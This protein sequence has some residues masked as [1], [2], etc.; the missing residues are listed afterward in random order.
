MIVDLNVGAKKVIVIGGGIEG[1]RKIKGLLGQ[2]CDITV[3]SNRLNKDLLTL[4]QKG[5]VNLIKR[6]INDA[7]ILNDFKNI[8]LILAATDNKTLNRELVAKGRTMGSFVYAS[9]DPSISDFSYASLTNIMGV[10]QVAISTSGK[11]PIMAR[12]IRMKVERFLHKIIKTSDV[13]NIILQDFARKAAKEKIKT[14]KE[15]KEFLYSLLKNKDIQN[16]IGLN[17]LDEAKLRT[18][19]LLDEWEAITHK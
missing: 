8:F 17:Q 14:V 10:I 1:M 11:S 4:N 5:E 12:T 3:I 7:S 15:R 2:S 6:K 9:D 13:E 16:Y 18:L 19:K